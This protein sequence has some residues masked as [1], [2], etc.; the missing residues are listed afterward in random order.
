MELNV[1]LVIG[2]LAAAWT[3]LSLL[4]GERQQKLREAEAQRAARMA[5][6]AAEAPPP[7]PDKKIKPPAQLP[8]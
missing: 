3:V 6:A 2:S 7:A 8:R 4:G 5:A 1:L